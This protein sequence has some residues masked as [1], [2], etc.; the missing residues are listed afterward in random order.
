VKT[1]RIVVVML[2]GAGWLSSPTVAFGQGDERSICSGLA[3]EAAEIA[4]LRAALA[5]NRPA[6]AT[7]RIDDAK[8]GDPASPL[9]AAV[10]HRPADLGTEQLPPRGAREQASAARIDARVV[11]AT[12]DPA[13]LLTVQL[14]N[15]QS[16]Q[17]TDMSG[18]P[19]R[20]NWVER[21][22]V[23]ITRSGFGGYRMRFPDK[24][25]QLPVRRL[26]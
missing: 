18:V 24:D 10:D 13:G 15:G 9:S 19:L 3:D 21:Q 20:A 5:A 4:C 17:Q 16:W 1:R 14:D 2:L 22:P 6:P 7:A 11:A 12:A 23:E 8:G 25:R 26:R